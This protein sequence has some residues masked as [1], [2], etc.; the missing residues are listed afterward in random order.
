MSLVSRILQ[1]QDL[2]SLLNYENKKLLETFPNEEERIFA[3]WNSRWRKEALEHY[4]KMGWS[5]IAH[6]GD[7]KSEAHPEGQIM[8]YFLAQPLIFFEGQ[9]Q[10]LWIE[11]LSY[12]TLTARDELCTLAYKLSREKHFQRVLFPN[13]SSVM[14]SITSF[15]PELWNPLMVTVKT[16]K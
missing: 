9:T 10:S 11:H 5:F 14:N 6:D 1:I 12:S 3:S 15:K 4:L 7:L 8:G 2:D 16:T 13:N